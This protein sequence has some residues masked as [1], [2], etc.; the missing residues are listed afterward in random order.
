MSKAISQVPFAINESVRTYEPGSD[1]VKS[2]I[3]T[4]KKMWKEKSAI[5]MI[6]NGK[7]V[8]S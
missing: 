7:E 1:E 3:A 2:L 4:Y 6:I 5:P 8:I